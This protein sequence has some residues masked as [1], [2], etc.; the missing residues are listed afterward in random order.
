[1]ATKHFGHPA[2]LVA[3]SL[4]ALS[5][6]APAQRFDDLGKQHLPFWQK[7]TTVSAA[8]DI[9]GDGDL[10]LALGA[11]AT[12]TLRLYR[13]DGAARFTAEAIPTNTDWVFGLVFLDAD[14]DGDA[15]LY[16]ARGGYDSLLLNDG[17]G[18]FVDASSHIP[19]YFASS[20]EVVAVDV[21]GDGDLDIVEANV[22]PAAN[23]LLINDGTGTFVSATLPPTGHSSIDVEV[24]D[25]DGDGDVDLVFG[26]DGTDSLMLNDG[27]GRFT[28]AG[29]VPWDDVLTHSIALAD[30]DGDGD[31]DL[32]AAVHPLPNL[33]L[34]RND[35]HAGFTDDGRLRFPVLAWSE[36]IVAAADIDRDGDAD[37]VVGDIFVLPTRLLRN[38][39]AGFFTDATA[40]VLPEAEGE[41]TTSAILARDFDLDGWLDLLLCSTR[42]DSHDE[43]L[44]NDGRGGF[45]S[46]TRPILPRS[47]VSSGKGA[48][49][50][51]LDGDGRVDLV[52]SSD[53]AQQV[54]LQR[55]GAHFANVTLD[56]LAP[57]TFGSPTS[58]ALGDIDRDGDLDVVVGAYG[59]PKRVLLNDG[60]AVFKDVTAT[61]LVTGNDSTN[62]VLLVDV[63]ND[64]DLDLVTGVSGQSRLFR[65][66]GDGVF[67]DD[68]AGSMPAQA[69]GT[70]ALAADDV[71]G[72]GDL[73]LVLGNSSTFATQSWLYLN[74]GSGHFADATATRLPAALFQTTDV[75]LGDVDGDGHPDLLLANGATRAALYVNDGTGTFHDV[76]GTHLPQVARG[77]RTAAADVDLDGDLDLLLTGVGTQLLVNDGSGSFTTAA[78]AVAAVAEIDAPLFA[79]LDDD[80]D[81]DLVDPG[82]PILYSNTTRQVQV[83]TVVR[84]GRSFDLVL[85]VDAPVPKVVMPFV[86]LGLAPHPITIP[87]LGR[88]ALEP[89]TLIGLPPTPVSGSTT[90]TLGL[91]PV[92]ALAGL[93]LCAQAVVAHDTDPSTWRLTNATQDTL[94]R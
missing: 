84:L 41:E 34:Y 87:P 83:P 26:N 11:G 57:P 44:L 30:F 90:L 10:D 5:A 71:D 91:P 12:P 50:G 85:L 79:D 35:G 17:T 43:L 80:G 89:A 24:G 4:A 22:Q 2:L 31:L 63:D 78:G 86:S 69:S 74:D 59:Y 20:R 73:D 42:S 64:G 70:R 15:D 39:G 25:L 33:R 58:L 8:A 76:S 56:A 82:F 75:V 28:S 37:L 27:A 60:H 21:D 16:V 51:D 29:N 47:Y 9:D 19:A 23:Q 65:N 54:L 14:R 1:M 81:V 66:R 13:N 62:D 67:A 53:L 6:S 40:A 18:T 61:H 93:P 52:I 48:A 45:A 55:P 38:D 77:D 3:T 32:V 88:M 49:A 92:V 72:D 94:L 36:A 68:T 7:G 46:G